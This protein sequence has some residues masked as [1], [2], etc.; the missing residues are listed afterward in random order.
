MLI[1]YSLAVRLAQVHGDSYR[2]AKMVPGG[3]RRIEILMYML[4]F[5]RGPQRPAHAECPQHHRIEETSC[6]FEVVHVVRLLIAAAGFCIGVLLLPGPIPRKK[7]FA[8]GRTWTSILLLPGPIP[9][10]K[11]IFCPCISLRVV[12]STR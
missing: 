8:A 11:S 6:H 2:L 10:K 3:H 1:V 5:A 12:L 7:L 9:C 4:Y